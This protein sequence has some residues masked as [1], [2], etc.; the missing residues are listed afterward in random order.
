MADHHED[1]TREQLMRRLR[2]RDKRPSFSLCGALGA[3]G[4]TFAAW[5]NTDFPIRPM[6]R[7]SQGL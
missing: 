5:R 2:E 4:L 6:R 7:K 1:Y 3:K